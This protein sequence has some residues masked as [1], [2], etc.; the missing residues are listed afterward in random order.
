[1]PW[2]VARSKAGLTCVA[3]CVASSLLVPPTAVAHEDPTIVHHI[4]AIAPALPAGIAVGLY[5]GEHTQLVVS[6]TTKDPVDVLDPAGV[7]YLRVS[8]DGATG[9]IESPYLAVTT[10][11]LAQA[12][13]DSSAPHPGGR[14]LQLSHKNGWAWADPRVDPAFLGAL[15]SGAGSGI[16]QM[17]ADRPLATW[18]IA[19]IHGGREYTVDGSL[20]RR[21]LGRLRYNV[22]SLPQGLS[23]DVVESRV[24]QIHLTSTEGLRIE[25]VGRD[26][27]PFLRID[28]RGTAARSAS[29]DYRDGMRA[30]GLDPETRP[31][32]VPLPGSGPSR[33]IW[34]DSRLRYTKAPPQVSGP[35]SVVVQKWQVP[36]VVNGQPGEIRGSTAWEPTANTAAGTSSPRTSQVHY[37]IAGGLT[38][39]LLA[40]FLFARRRT[41]SA[42]STEAVA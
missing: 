19:M 10:G 15:R 32:W 6:N 31:A 27:L 2:K 7:P 35:Y 4:D 26:G 13:P 5:E 37:V 38:A 1:M 28:A 42:N 25:V 22:D 14:W 29:L 33:A 24:P 17:Q 8:I 16:G 20:T 9:N 30:L 18:R 40:A 39:L 21:A 41:T 12:K 36:V 23:V 3:V 34:P 11:V